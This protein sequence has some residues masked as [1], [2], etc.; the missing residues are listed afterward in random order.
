MVCIVS[1][2]LSKSSIL[3]LQIK[4]FHIYIR[5]LSNNL[6]GPSRDYT[7]IKIYEDMY[8]EI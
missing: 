6:K 8:L 3:E 1:N 4:R 7:S 5:V 2:S